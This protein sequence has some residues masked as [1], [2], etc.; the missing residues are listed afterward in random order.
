[1]KLLASPYSRFSCNILK[2][3]SFWQVHILDFPVIFSKLE[4]KIGSDINSS[5]SSFDAKVAPL[6][7]TYST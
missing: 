2:I 4:F 5:Q 1:M 7:L 3:R 6:I